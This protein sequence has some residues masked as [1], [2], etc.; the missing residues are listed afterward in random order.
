MNKILDAIK[1]NKATMVCLVLIA[2]IITFSA[3]AT[4]CTPGDMIKQD[5]PKPMQIFNDGQS[6][7]S[8]NDAPFVL[9]AYLTDCQRTVEQF[10]AANER[11]HAFF[12]GLNTLVTFGI[13]E[14]GNS[15][16]PGASIASGLLLGLAG[17]MMKKPGTAKMIADEKMASFNKGL[18]M[19]TA[20]VAE[21][22]SVVTPE[23]LAALVAALKEIKA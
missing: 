23:T 13:G 7:V 17:L 3:F 22:K 6:K 16:I 20:K 2:F 11:A 5:V 15:P 18:E 10:V 19:A 8:L 4:G 9:D 1:D 12:D 21:Q 14:L